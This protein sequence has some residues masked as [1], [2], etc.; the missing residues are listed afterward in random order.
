MSARFRLKYSPGARQPWKLRDAARPAF[1]GQYSTLDVACR[2]MDNTIRREAGM[3][4]RIAVSAAE[5]QAAMRQRA[6]NLHDGKVPTP[7]LIVKPD[8]KSS[9]PFPAEPNL[10]ERD[11]L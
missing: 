2:A 10:I 11:I 6:A 9:R 4:E 7:P 5:V 8:G 3:P 1:L